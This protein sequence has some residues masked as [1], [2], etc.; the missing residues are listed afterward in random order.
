M[1][2][3]SHN[4][5]LWMLGVEQEGAVGVESVRRL[6]RTLSLDLV[7]PG[8]QRELAIILCRKSV[9]CSFTS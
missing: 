3:H 7:D 1:Q 4:L 9:C 2:G 5:L 8:Q 6:G